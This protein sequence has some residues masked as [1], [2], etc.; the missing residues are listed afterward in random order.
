[1]AQPAGPALAVS[2]MSFARSHRRRD[3]LYLACRSSPQRWPVAARRKIQCYSW[4]CRRLVNSSLTGRRTLPHTTGGE[5]QRHIT[6]EHS[7][8]ALEQCLA[9]RTQSQPHSW[10]PVCGNMTR[11]SRG[12]AAPPQITARRFAC[13]RPSGEGRPADR[14]ASQH[15][16][17]DHA[18]SGTACAWTGQHRGRAA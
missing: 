13:R 15:T 12:R 9:R 11:I 17:A 4:M 3:E 10:A 5:P 8:H 1:M 18:R 7:H 2:A 6:P 16:S 14:P